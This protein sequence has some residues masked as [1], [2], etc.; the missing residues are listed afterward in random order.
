M[1]PARKICDLEQLVSLRRKARATGKSVV[2]CHG[3]FDIVHPGH[4]HHLEYARSLGD[5]LFVTVSSDTHVAKGVNRPLIPDDL[6]ARNLAALQAVDVVYVNP[7]PTAVELL[8]QLAPDVYVKGR[9]YEN[10]TDPRFL[11]ERDTVIQNGGRV[12]FS[13]GDVVYSSTALINTLS[14]T[15]AFEDEKLRRFRDRYDISAESL[16]NLVHRF[17][18]L[19]VVVIGDYMLDR[20]HFCEA[21]GIAGEAPVISLRSVNRAEYDG[22]A[23]VVALHLASLGCSPTLVTMMADDDF[24]HAAKMRMTA[25]GVNVS[26]VNGRKSTIIKE[27]YLVE[28]T[29]MFRVEEGGAAPLDS[30]MEA[31]F[32]SMLFDAAQ[33]ADAVIFT[34]FGYGTLTRGLLERVTAPLRK[35]VAILAADVSG[36]QGDLLKFRGMDLICPTEREAR[37]CIGDHASG[38]GAVV[39]KMLGKIDSRQALITLGKQ[40][41]VTFDWPTPAVRDSGERLRSEY[42]PAF[43]RRG[44]DPLGCGDA[45]LA[46]ATATLAAGGDLMSAALL[47]SYA[48]ALEVNQ[49][50]NIPITA[51]ELLRLTADTV[52][53]RSAT[54]LAI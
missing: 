54:R 46:T 15:D 44:I 3:C 48:A 30:M 10:S 11:R 51:D 7:H 31:R 8:E 38:L 43:A 41:L 19:K 21:L 36:S 53:S 34:D 35:S 20:Y 17:R 24:A 49:V 16:A 4:V 25:A 50:G 28:E 33:G 26:S 27:R 12:V 40:G 32:S 52:Q 29:K 5:L 39:S 13:G 18:D 22:G 47:G 2:H 23:G 37:Q 6:R 1:T 45:L 9:E 42:I 14:Q